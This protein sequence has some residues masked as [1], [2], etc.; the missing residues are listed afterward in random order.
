M[1]TGRCLLSLW[2]R[3]RKSVEPP[4]GILPV[5]RALPGTCP[6]V[7]PTLCTLFVSPRN[8][9]PRL[10][11]GSGDKKRDHSVG[12]YGS[13]RL[14]ILEKQPYSFASVFLSCRARLSRKEV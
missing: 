1:P 12:S 9:E 11:E 4:V 13:I 3:R 6:S 8:V 10:R 14:L 2:C 5:S 7:L